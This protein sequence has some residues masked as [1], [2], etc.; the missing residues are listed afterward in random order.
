MRSCLNAPISYLFGVVNNAPTHT[1]SFKCE[2]QTQCLRNHF[3][4][5]IIVGYYLVNQTI[6]SKFYQWD[7]CYDTLGKFINLL[8]YHH[9]FKFKLIFFQI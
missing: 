5:L 2:T 1:Y 4:S 8:T 9:N 6:L 3:S 7:Y